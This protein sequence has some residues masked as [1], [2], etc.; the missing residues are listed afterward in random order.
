MEGWKRTH[1]LGAL[2][3]SDAGKTVTLM[4]WVHRRRDHGGLVFLDLR[5]REGITQVVLYPDL[6]GESHDLAHQV[7]SEYVVAIEGVVVE[8]PAETANKD[9]P[10]GDI[11]VRA[12][13]L[14]ILNRAK[15][16]PFQIA[17]EKTDVGEDLRLKYRYLDLRRPELQNNLRM[18]HKVTSAAR[19]F[20]EAEGFWDVETPV[21]TKS[22]PEGARDFLVPSRLSQTNFYALPQSPQ[23]FKQLLMVAGVDRYYQIVKCFRDEDLRADRQPEF[24]QIDLEMSFVDQDDVMELMEKMVKVIWKEAVDIA[25]EGKFPRLG[26]ADA[27]SRY[28][29]DAP[30]IRFGLELAEITEVVADSDFK[31]F[32]QVAASGGAVKGLNAKGAGEALTR[33]E[34][35]DL[36]GFVAPFGAKGLAWIRIQPDGQWQSPIAKFLGDKARE[37]IVKAFSP[38]PGDIMFFVADK[39]EVANLSLARLRV[40]LGRRLGLI[41]DS[42]LGFCWITDFPLVEWNEEDKRYYALHHPFTSPRLDEAH[43]MES[44]PL[45]VRAKAYD[46]VLNGTEV[47]GGSIR[48]HDRDIQ[49]ALFKVLG[50]GEEEAMEK[51][52]FLLEGLSY[53][54]P[55][56][57]GIAFGLD[58]L[59]MFLCK[60]DSIRD[61]IAFPKTQKGTC[62]M[63]D[64]PSAV[65]DKQ[66]R[67]LGIRLRATA[68]A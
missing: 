33:K 6:S 49:N 53:G 57:G 66:L 17:D 1:H 64:A 48:I 58:R 19:R 29:C 68:Q 47:G 21:L 52:G 40:H 26:Y 60:A 67:E 55:P 44:E 23:L 65:D 16:P 9:L 18:R 31:V 14:A 51:F 30:D 20:L 28:G 7:R 35:D 46:L 42:V 24:T 10:T 37:G 38:V 59:C 56:H 43:L 32:A 4:G 36:A 8:R 41:D 61:V 3:K 13:R 22:T 11:E 62:L 34:I 15:T 63:T 27:L 50:I 54:A 39:R 5:D 45:K 12:K 25:V 2:R